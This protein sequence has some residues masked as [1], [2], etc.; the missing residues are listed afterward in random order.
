MDFMEI[1]TQTPAIGAILL[2]VA[3]NHKALSKRD[4]TLKEIGN[5]CH[6]LWS[7]TTESLRENSRVLGESSE[8]H[9]ATKDA[10]QEVAILLKTVNGKR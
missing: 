4:C 3:W 9:R 10:L 2:I 5:H 6:E 7:N 1:A 8:V